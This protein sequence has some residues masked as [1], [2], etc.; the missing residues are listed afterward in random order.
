M[1]NED[2]VIHFLFEATQENSE[3][4]PFPLVETTTVNATFADDRMWTE[5][6]NR[7]LGFLGSVYGYD[8]KNKVSVYDV[9]IESFLFSSSDAQWAAMKA[10]NQN[11]SNPKTEEPNFFMGSVSDW[12]DEE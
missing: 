4:T 6:L 11:P 7:F 1:N 3:N 12:D 9:P 2:N 8:I 10:F 5:V